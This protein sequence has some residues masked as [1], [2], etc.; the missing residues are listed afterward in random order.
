MK[1]LPGFKGIDVT[2][3]KVVHGPKLGQTSVS[4]AKA[5]RRMVSRSRN[6]DSWAPRGLKVVKVNEIYRVFAWV[7]IRF[8]V[9]FLPDF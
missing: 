5:D 4:E 2:I 9:V 7:F 6:L 3:T 1:D 8:Q